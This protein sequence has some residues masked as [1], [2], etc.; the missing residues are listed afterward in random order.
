MW[1]RRTA[2]F[3]HLF[4]PSFCAHPFCGK[5]HAEHRRQRNQLSCVHRR[6]EGNGGKG[7]SCKEALQEKVRW[8]GLAGSPL[9]P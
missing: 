5:P 1:A 9:T 8:R 2:C 4:L 7:R 6:P 3:S